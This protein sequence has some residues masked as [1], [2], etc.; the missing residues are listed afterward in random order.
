[1]VLQAK[2]C[3]TSSLGPSLHVSPKNHAPVISKD[4]I[5]M[6]DTVI[7]PDI[8]MSRA[9]SFAI[10][11]VITLLMLCQ[12]QME[13]NLTRPVCMPVKCNYKLFIEAKWDIDN[14]FVWY[15]F[16]GCARSQYCDAKVNCIFESFSCK[17]DHWYLTPNELLRS[18]RNCEIVSCPCAFSHVFCDIY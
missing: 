5:N 12:R 16:L 2:S 15:I 11:N 14:W 1:M 9:T 6:A 17:G 8:N 4:M 10:Q 13:H 18:Q 7:Y 3:L